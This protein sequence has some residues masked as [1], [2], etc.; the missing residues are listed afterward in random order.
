[1][2]VP[3]YPPCGYLSLKILGLGSSVFS[4]EDR[5]AAKSVHASAKGPKY[6]APIMAKRRTFDLRRHSSDDLS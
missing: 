2:H 3:S 6:L 1:M 5:S 4:L